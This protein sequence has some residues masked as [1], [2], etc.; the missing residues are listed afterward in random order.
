MNSRLLNRVYLSP[1]VVPFILIFACFYHALI[2][3]SENSLL[4]LLE[5]L[6]FAISIS[7]V[8]FLLMY[9]SKYLYSKLLNTFLIIS[10]YAF[11][12][13]FSYQYY[14]M[15]TFSFLEIEYLANFIIILTLIYDKRK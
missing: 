5:R 14:Q 10:V 8:S 11:V 3:S 7:T 13:R 12:I 6:L 1:Y 2:S 9:Y 4:H 15:G